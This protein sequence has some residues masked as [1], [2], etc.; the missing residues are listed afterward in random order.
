M[1]ETPVPES[2]REILR[3]IWA[4][5]RPDFTFADPE[6]RRRALLCG[7]GPFVLLGDL[8]RSSILVGEPGW[9]RNV[10]V[11]I[12]AGLS[13]AGHVGLMLL[14]AKAGYDL[15]TG[16][17]D[18]T[19]VVGIVL[20]ALFAAVPL[21]IAARLTGPGP[22]PMPVFAI[23]GKDRLA[24][25]IVWRYRDACEFHGLY[26]QAEQVRLA[27]AE[28]LGWQARHR[29]DVHFPDHRHVPAVSR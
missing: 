3:Q 6:R 12:C 17:Q 10:R 7:G 14:V 2:F 1:T 28:I 8:A 27:H 5:F 15:W 13:T 9:R 26:D 25:E 18:R 23:K 19:L 24:N 21:F 22:D 16:Q 11:G 29:D 4:N 20:A